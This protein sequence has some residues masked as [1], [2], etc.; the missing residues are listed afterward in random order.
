MNNSKM[1]HVINEAIIVRDNKDSKY[2]DYK[3]A[4]YKI[5]NVQK[6]LIQK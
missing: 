2:Q 6:E 4:V 3:D 1:I 5:I